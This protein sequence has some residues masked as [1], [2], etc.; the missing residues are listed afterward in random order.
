MAVLDQLRH[1]AIEE[2][3]Q[4]RGDV[5]AVDVGVGH[6]DDPLVAQPVV[7]VVGAGAAA[8]RLDQVL[9]LLVL[10]QLV[11]RWRWPR[12]GSCR[13]AAGSPGSRGCAPPWP[14]RRPNRPRP[15]R[16]RCRRPRSCCSRRACRAGA[17][18]ASRSCAAARGPACGAAA[19][20]PWRSTCSSRTLPAS[21][22]PVS[23]CSK[24]SPTMVSTSL[25]A[26]T[27]TSFSLVWPWNCGCSMNTE[28]RP[29]APSITS[30]AVM[31][32][33]LAVAGELGIALQAAHQRAAE[34]RFVRAALGRRHGVAVGADEAFLVV[35][36]PH[37]PFDLAAGRAVGLA[38]GLAGE[39]LRH[40]GRPLA[41][42]R[43][44]VVL[45]AAGEVERF[46]LGDRAV[47]GQQAL[48]AAPADLDAA[49]QVGLGARHAVEPLGH[50][51]LLAEDL[52]DRDGR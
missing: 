18:C 31:I 12:S 28:T 42:L 41:D 27:L 30:S 34:A 37:R 14:S 48:V 45:Q 39:G 22:S 4:Q 3:H 46:L 21:L 1:L 40:D 51:G 33:A 11:G 47:L 15:G 36:P 5:G 44:Q 29:A 10:A 9:D 2:R 52:R 19:P 49:E 20:R 8:Q 17:A 32:D 25:V 6:D 43:D 35:R 50:E 26:S 16:S 24:L 38:L 23:Q 13:A 7:V